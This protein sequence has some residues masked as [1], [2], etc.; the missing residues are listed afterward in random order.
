MGIV[1]GEEIHETEEY[2]YDLRETMTFGFRD[3]PELLDKL[4][5]INDG[6]TIAEF[7]QC[8]NHYLYI[9]NNDP[10]CGVK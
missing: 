5:L 8:Q 1:K 4:S 2:F 9:V 10:I 6:Q 7:I 3:N